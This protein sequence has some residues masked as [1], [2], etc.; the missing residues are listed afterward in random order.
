MGHECAGVAEEVG[1][2][3]RTIKPGQFVVGAFSAS[4]STGEIRRAGY[5]SRC[6][7]AEPIGDIGTRAELARRWCVTGCGLW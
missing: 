4:D 3:I 2:D 5:Q 6:V 7:H 1:R